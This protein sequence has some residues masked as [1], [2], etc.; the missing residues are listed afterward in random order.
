M[1]SKVD[2]E[3][4]KHDCITMNDPNIF[5]ETTSKD[6]ISKFSKA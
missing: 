5:I 6:A 2:V 3:T 4:K 1:Q